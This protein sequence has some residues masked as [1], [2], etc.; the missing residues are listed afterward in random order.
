[1]DFLSVERRQCEALH[2]E[3]EN[4]EVGCFFFKGCRKDVA[5]QPLKRPQICVLTSVVHA[6]LSTDIHTYIH[7]YSR[8]L[9]KMESN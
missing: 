1:M 7:T 8:S 3:H 2:T 6:A 4:N 9:K 5:F